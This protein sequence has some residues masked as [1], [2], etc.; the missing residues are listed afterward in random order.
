MASIMVFGVIALVLLDAKD[1]VWYPYLGT[2]L[3]AIIEEI[4]LC[5][6]STV[7]VQPWTQFEDMR[8]AVQIFRIVLLALLFAAS[9]NRARPQNK[10]EVAVDGERRPLLNGDAPAPAERATD[11]GT[12]TSSETASA[13]D[14]AEDEGDEEDREVRKQQRKRIEEQGGWW[15][16]L[17]GFAIF[18]PY[19]FP[20]KYRGA[21]L[22]MAI[23][24]LC[25]I[26]ERFLNV[27]T[28]RQLGIITNKLAEI[29]GPGKFIRLSIDVDCF[30]RVHREAR[31]IR[32]ISHSCDQ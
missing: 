5:V 20:L 19:I 4:V 22:C 7:S 8:L 2:W 26:A 21:Q 6:L 14:E 1:P 31:H 17:K 30:K 11:Y 25:I 10:S 23:L 13:K 18:L 29:D 28:P 15:G 12:G 9:V 32:R 3:L 16:Y 27:L 24:G